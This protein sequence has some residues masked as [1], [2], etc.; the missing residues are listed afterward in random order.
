M[1]EIAQEAAEEGILWNTIEASVLRNVLTGL[2]R[3]NLW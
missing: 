3:E 1:E 2:R